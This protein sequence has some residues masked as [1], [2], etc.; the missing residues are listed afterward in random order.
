MRR[1]ALLTLAVLLGAAV[2]PAA[3]QQAA[4]YGSV[5]DASRS[6]LPGATVT[7]VN[8]R[9]GLTQVAVT[10]DRGE[11]RVPSLPPGLYSVTAELSG[12]AAVTQKDLTVGLEAQV[13]VDVVLELAS[14]REAVTVVAESPLV[15]TRST[16]VG[17]N[18]TAE[19]IKT[20][21][22]TGRQWI[23]LATLMPGTGQD[24]IRAQFY[25]SVNIG[26]GINF[27]SNGFYVDNVTNNWQ[28]QGEPRQDF[29]QDSI[30]EF[31]VYSFNAPPVYG[32]AQ[33]G[34]LSAVTKSGTNEFH[35]DVFEFYRDK[36]LNART[37]FQTAKPDYRRHQVGGALGGPV[38]R[39]RAQFFGSYEYTGESLFITVY[40]RG[41]HP[42]Y[43]E[44]FKAPQWNHMFV[45]RFDQ[46][47]NAQHR[48]FV[49]YALQRNLLS[50]TGAGGIAARSAGSNFSA[51]RDAVVVGETWVLSKNTVNEF[52][53]QRAM[54]TYIGWPSV[55]GL[56][57]T[58]AGA[59]PQ[60]RLA[61]LP[62]VI[63]RPTL[64]LGNLSSFIGPERRIELK[65]DLTYIA[66]S[67]ELAVG[68]D[69]N[70]I[71]WT[72]DN[73]GSNR[74]FSFAT[75]APFDPGNR[76]TYPFNFQQRL[77]PTFD[78]VPSTEHSLY[79][80]DTWR[81][82]S[83]LT[84]N[85]GLRYDVQT[86]VWNENLLEHPQ[87]EVKLV[88]RVLRPAGRLDPALFPFY[89]AS[90]R[91]DWNNFGPRVG[92][93]W[94]VF[95]TGRQTIRAAY[96]LYYNRYRANPQR[97]ELSPLQLLVI[98]AN[99]NYP[100]PYQGRDPFELA[101]AVRNITI[102]GN[103]NRTPY[104]HQV[105]AGMTRQLGSNMAVSLDGTIAN[106]SRQHTT[107]DLNY[108]ADPTARAAR[109]RPNPRFGQVQENLTDGTL[110][111]RAVE[112]RVNRR[113]ADRWQLMGSYTLAY[114]KNTN[115]GLPADHF[116]RG[117]EY[118]WA[119]ADRRHRLTVSGI[120]QLFYGIQA[121]A[122]VRYQSSLAVNIT[123]GRDLNGDT[124]TNDRPPG[125][126]RNTGCRGLDLAA[127]N[128]Y[129]Q[130]NNLAPVSDFFC[131]GYASLD[132]QASKTVRLGGQRNL[133]IILQIFN[134]TNRSN[135]TPAVGNA[136]S[137]LFGQSQAVA[138]P[139]QGEV[140]VRFNF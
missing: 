102:Q 98:I 76:A 104:T 72:P 95:G 28:Q 84:I 54:A 64:R 56:K 109:I 7:V 42:Q 94:D 37:V 139:R 73:F 24:A 100:D 51:P 67:H 47:I 97:A 131:G 18:V 52:R 130:A 35:G 77:S 26:A 70:W 29:P 41:I 135:Y 114:A 136:L 55:P 138:S 13:R 140:A 1:L 14:V 123:A 16:S 106:G 115:E 48:L 91:G 88:D 125:I 46:T 126:T 103:L 71:L 45:G 58:R 10:N 4:I 40:T 12:F 15:D 21:P 110:R 44:T 132:V 27:Y 66:G 82:T 119:D 101:A 111:Y 127:V 30:A 2:L 43:E 134:V 80:G 112:L 83:R 65:D 60:E 108:F 69:L 3:A 5:V 118:G 107:I 62:D 68:V 63:T 34:Y 116:D 79:V 124:I 59:F 36:S 99:P 8:Q 93:T 89:D 129:R 121:S 90:T 38:V 120:A 17:G 78:D 133:E 57:W 20:L 31:K 49:R 6:V 86:G 85:G 25:N 39:N 122:I 113:M 74:Q 50:Y 87:P 117:A 22:V 61:S 33:G 75:D 53:F 81:P 137:P 9:T 92:M 105:S 96:G 32:F 19:Q 11:Y 23:N 128:A